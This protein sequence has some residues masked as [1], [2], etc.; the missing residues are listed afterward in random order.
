MD[1]VYKVDFWLM[2]GAKFV[3]AWSLVFS[4][5]WQCSCVSSGGPF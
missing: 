1:Q 3:I 5:A 4:V 2:S